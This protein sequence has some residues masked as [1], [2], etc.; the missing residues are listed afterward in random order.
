MYL[1]LYL[2]FLFYTVDPTGDLCIA[3]TPFNDRP[4]ILSFNRGYGWTLFIVLRHPLF[5]PMNLVES[6]R[7]VRDTKQNRIC[8]IFIGLALDLAVTSERVAVCRR[9][10]CSVQR[11]GVLS[12]CSSFL[13]CLSGVF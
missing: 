11:Q 8:Y 4:F 1:G 9:L 3:V 2:D 7:L 12:V 13:L 10:S 5:F 6:I